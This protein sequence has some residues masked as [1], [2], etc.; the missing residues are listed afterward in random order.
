MERSHRQD[1][2]PKADVLLEVQHVHNRL[3][4]TRMEGK[5]VKRSNVDMETCVCVCAYTLRVAAGL[6][7]SLAVCEQ[8]DPGHRDSQHAPVLAGFILRQTHTGG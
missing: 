6:R 5:R 3:R 7:Q 2:V 4:C 1:A 8:S